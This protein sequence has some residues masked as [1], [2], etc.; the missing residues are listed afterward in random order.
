[1]NRRARLLVVAAVAA[2]IVAACDE[3]SEVARQSFT[4][5]REGVLSVAADLPAEGFWNG[6]ELEVVETSFPDIVAGRLGD[7]D[8]ALSQVSITSERDNLTFSPPYYETASGVVTRRDHEDITDLLTAREQSWAAESASTHLEFVEDTIRPDGAVVLAADGAMA[9]EE[10]RGGIVDAAL[11]DL[12]AALVLTHED[13][14][15][16]TSARFNTEERFGVVVARDTDAAR[17]NAE[18]VD[19]AI[20]ALRS[21]GSLDDFASTWL[22]PVFEKNPDDLP[23]IR[24]RG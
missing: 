17:L 18:A 13:A 15:V 3:A 22:D 10:V 19:A 20:R 6:L 7:A 5:K 12:S 21:D 2:G 9:I 1:M 14:D 23:V 16:T 4:P 11:L 8:L 24:F